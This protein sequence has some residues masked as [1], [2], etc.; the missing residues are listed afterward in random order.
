MLVQRIVSFVLWCLSPYNL[1][2]PY[3]WLY[4][5][6]GYCIAYI[7]QTH[8]H[9][10]SRLRCLPLY[11]FVKPLINTHRLWVLTSF[12]LEICHIRSLTE[13]IGMYVWVCFSTI[14]L[15]FGLSSQYKIGDFVA[16]QRETLNPIG[17]LL[18]AVIIFISF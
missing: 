4:L 9:A 16:R 14:E 10:T 13:T 11:E 17:A 6:L 3:I 12:Q 2:R 7:I 18:C 5:W 8:I 1:R 15:L